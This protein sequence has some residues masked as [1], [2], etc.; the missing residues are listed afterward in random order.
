MKKLL[1]A[2]CM[3]AF[4]AVVTNAQQLNNFAMY[5]QEGAPAYSV[6]LRGL[7][8]NVDSSR[9][10]DYDVNNK[11]FGLGFEWR[12]SRLHVAGT[13][14]Y[15]QAGYP[16]NIDA[17]L[18]NLSTYGELYFEEDAALNMQLG[19]TWGNYK[20][21]GGKSKNPTLRMQVFGTKNLEAG[22]F[23]ITPTAGMRYIYVNPDEGANEDIFTLLGGAKAGLSFPAQGMTINPE[24]GAAIGY[25]L[26]RPSSGAI[27]PLSTGA[28]IM[29]MDDDQAR[30]SFQPYAGVTFALENNFDIV[31][32]YEGDWRSSFMNHT[33]MMT[34]RYNFGPAVDRK[35]VAVKNYGETAPSYAALEPSVLP[36]YSESDVQYP[37]DRPVLNTYY[38]ADVTPAPANVEVGDL[39][40]APGVFTLG[41]NAKA[42]LTSK[43]A[44]IK[45]TR[46]NSVTVSGYTDNKEAGPNTLSQSRAV[47]VSG[48]LIGQG[49]NSSKIKTYFYGAGNP[50]RPNSTAAGQKM[51]RRV[52]VKVE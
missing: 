16:A 45:A 46:Y 28:A 43:A 37:E 9:S 36:A 10:F 27:I 39:Y 12:T 40:F 7:V 26:A 25:D 17:D 44:E 15:L 21:D 52:E 14:D 24:F 5:E 38:E 34:L 23:I 33:G 48:F 31:L 8:G 50:V 41:P 22:R 2:A 47:V 1:T 19:Y 6:W 30:L 49:I 3:V 13:Y 51:N 29:G 11:G 4:L 35:Y 42:Y 32:S 20:S 18:H